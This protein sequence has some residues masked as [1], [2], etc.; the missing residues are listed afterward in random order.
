M[1]HRPQP[2]QRPS[3]LR[4]A[5]QPPPKHKLILTTTYLNLK[6]RRLLPRRLTL[7]L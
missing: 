7:Q 1:Q 3:Q 6:L 4:P 5:L 2:R